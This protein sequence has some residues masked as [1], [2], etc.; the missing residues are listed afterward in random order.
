MVPQEEEQEGEEG[1]EGEGRDWDLLERSLLSSGG[2]RGGGVSSWMERYSF[3]TS[4]G[5]S[6]QPSPELSARYHSSPLSSATHSLP[7]SINEIHRDPPREGSP[8]S[9]GRPTMLY[10][11]EEFGIFGAATVPLPGREKR[12][13]PSPG[14]LGLSPSA[15]LGSLTPLSPEKKEHPLRSALRSKSPQLALRR[16]SGDNRGPLSG[17]VYNSPDPQSPPAINSRAFSKESLRLPPSQR[18]Q[19]AMTV[20]AISKARKVTSAPSGALRTANEWK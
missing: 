18:Y 6:P 11:K 5:R 15:P 9:G 13:P 3:T 10:S 8:V 14:N 20:A 16:L 17:P 12:K 2:E 1:E 4:T 19:E 7:L